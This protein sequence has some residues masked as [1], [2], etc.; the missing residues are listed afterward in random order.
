[1]IVNERIRKWEE[2]IRKLQRKKDDVV[3]NCDKK[4]RELRRK[5]QDE[6]RILELENNQMIADIVR[7]AYGEVTAD[8]V[9]LFKQNLASLMPAANS[10]SDEKNVETDHGQPDGK[11]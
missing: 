8:N 11:Y 2:E 3:Q 1:M 6:A 5:I 7:T 9:E 4:I 10:G